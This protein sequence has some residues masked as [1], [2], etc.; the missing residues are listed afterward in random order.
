MVKFPQDFPSLISYQRSDNLTALGIMLPVF[1]GAH[2]V[3]K[4]ILTSLICSENDQGRS[5]LKLRLRNMLNQETSWMLAG[6]AL[7]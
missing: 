2:R 5:E 3:L 7:L 1:Q 6:L 4:V